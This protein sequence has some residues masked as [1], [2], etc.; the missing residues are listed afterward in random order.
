M[1]RKKMRLRI[2]GDVSDSTRR[3]TGSQG[4][5]AD[6]LRGAV[7]GSGVKNGSAPQSLWTRG[8]EVGGNLSFWGSG[9]WLHCLRRSCLHLLEHVLSRAC[10]KIEELF[11]LLGRLSSKFL[12]ELSVQFQCFW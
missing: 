10:G 12:E 9:G 1:R 11:R 6:R 8:N 5:P 2:D 7:G 3:R 4:R